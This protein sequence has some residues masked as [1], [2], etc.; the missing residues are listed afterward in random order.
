MVFINIKNQFKY[1]KIIKVI[2]I[3]SIIFIILF[4]ILWLI[5]SSLQSERDLFRKIPSF[6]PTHIIFKNYLRV[7]A[8]KSFVRAMTNSCI[9]SGFT[10]LLTLSF[11][12]APA[13]AFSR[14][15]FR[16]KSG[17][18]LILLASQFFPAMTFVIPY[19]FIFLRTHLLGTHIGLIFINFVFMSPFSIWILR[20]FFLAIPQEIE[21]AAMLD[22]CSFIQMLLKIVLP[23]VTPGILVT[24]M[25][26]FISSWSQFLF[27][28]VLTNSDSVTL[29]VRISGYLGQTIIDYSSLFAAGVLTTIPALIAALS[30]QKYLV[31]G[32]TAGGVKG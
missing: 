28:L 32:M 17:F 19:Y 5:I 13:Y 8:D 31:S 7:L 29:P 23:L 24:A 12:F 10:V 1:F 4:P 16:F 27:A 6:I 2:L 22:G 20:S 18:M 15:S 26:V 25:F 9:I 11:A 30:I 14:F 21:E 3:W